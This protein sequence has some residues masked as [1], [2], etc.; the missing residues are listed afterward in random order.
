VASSEPIPSVL[1]GAASLRRSTDHTVTSISRSTEWPQLAADL[2]TIVLALLL[3]PPLFAGALPYRFSLREVTSSIA[4]AMLVGT[5]FAFTGTYSHY[6]T[7]LNI[8]NTVGLVKGL[9]CTAI[10]GMINHL[11]SSAA[12]NI[13]VVTTFPFIAVLLIAQR[14]AIGVTTG[15]SSRALLCVPYEGCTEN[16]RRTG[17]STTSPDNLITT[18]P[19]R[20]SGY[21]LKR[22]VDLCLASLLILLLTPLFMAVAV[23]I[24]W[25]SRGPALLRQR[26]IGRYGISFYMWKFRSMYIDSPR[27]AR[28][29]VSDTDPRL[30][31]IGR[32]IR[33]FSIDE[34][35]QLF[36]VL[37]GN[38]SLVGP[39]PEMPFIVAKYS[40]Y[41]RLRLSALPGMT[42]LWQISPARAMPIHQ[43]VH[44]DLFYIQR[45]SIFLDLAI[46]LRTA[47]ATVRGIGAA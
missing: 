12:S 9:C 35:P 31:K 11:Q 23:G 17:F 10:L 40:S 44:L 3:I 27:Y 24:R 25:E 8:G 5:I 30:T 29:P 45:Q 28:S 22:A 37:A 20:R 32:L 33:R 7:P 6:E 38:M 34:L 36:N 18:F 19:A 42:G 15:N 43:N 4:S 14:E 46:M 39:R 16:E 41:E 1:R 2:I 21:L 47:T 26:R 13:S